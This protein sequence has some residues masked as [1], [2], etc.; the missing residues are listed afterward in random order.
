MVFN[1]LPIPPLD[2]SKVFFSLL[3]S[4]TLSFQ[5]QLERLGPMLLI[6]VILLDQFSGVGLF[7]WLFSGISNF[8]FSMI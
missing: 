4:S 7:Q 1:L 3:P 6:G 5:S 2:G 8:V